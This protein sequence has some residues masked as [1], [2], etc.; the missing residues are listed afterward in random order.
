MLR[1]AAL[2]A[3]ANLDCLIRGRPARRRMLI[4]GGLLA[5]VAALAFAA[6]ADPRGWVLAAQSGA[7][8]T[9]LD[10]LSDNDAGTRS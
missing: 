4:G 7:V 2:A 10:A 5:I 1:D 9:L 8:P 3:G 6:G